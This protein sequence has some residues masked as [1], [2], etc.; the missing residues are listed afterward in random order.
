MS[1]CSFC[2]GV[3]RCISCVLRNTGRIIIESPVSVNVALGESRKWPTYVSGFLNFAN[4]TSHITR[5]KYMGSTSVLFKEFKGSGEG[6]T[7]VEDWRRF[8]ENRV[9]SDDGASGKEAIQQAGAKLYAQVDKIR[10]ELNN[11]T[12]SD[13]EDY[14]DDL[15]I[16]KSFAGHGIEEAMLRKIAE[17]TNRTFTAS[18]LEDERKGIDGFLDDEPVSVKPSTYKYSPHDVLPPKIYFYAL[19]ENDVRSDQLWRIVDEQRY[20]FPRNW[21]KKKVWD[22]LVGCGN[23]LFWEN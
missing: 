12:P 20:D 5:V 9:V 7:S 23:I 17:K 8:Y 13:C 4:R 14:I 3:Q 16:N 22:A 10:R 15:L 6:V 18:T 2:N 21:T 19:S 1:L 11:I